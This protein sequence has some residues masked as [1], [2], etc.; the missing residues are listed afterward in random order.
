MSDV[1]LSYRGRLIRAADVTFL[2]ELIAQN[3]TLS[4]RRLSAKVCEAWQWVQPNGQLRDMV[5]RG[6]ML[7]LH[8]AGQI[9]RARQATR[10]DQ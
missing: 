8:R 7:A 6:L 5:C 9:Q 2:R 10:Y 3:P 4:R 1:L